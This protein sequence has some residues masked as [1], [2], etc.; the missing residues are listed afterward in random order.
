MISFLGAR[1]Y[2]SALGKFAAPAE[3]TAKVW[4]F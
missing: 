1:K 3:T 2:V 4:A